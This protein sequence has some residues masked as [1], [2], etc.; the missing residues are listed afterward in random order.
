MLYAADLLR[1]ETLR[2]HRNWEHSVVAFFLLGVIK[3]PEMSQWLR[4]QR[5]I[6]FKLNLCYANSLAYR[7][8]HFVF[9]SFTLFILLVRVKMTISEYL[10]GL[11][12]VAQLISKQL[13]QTEK[14]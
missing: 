8:T 9:A 5:K 11:L 1:T 4:I 6:M 2:N 3:F 10:A 13:A 14:S 12:F 7:M